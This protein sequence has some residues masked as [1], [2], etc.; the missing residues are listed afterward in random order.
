MCGTVKAPLKRVRRKKVAR[1]CMVDRELLKRGDQIS[2]KRFLQES[3]FK[4]PSIESAP[5]V[6]NV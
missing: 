5:V 6:R 3:G 4:K 2:E 1:V